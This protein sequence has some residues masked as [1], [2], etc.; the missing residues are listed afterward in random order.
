MQDGQEILP[1]FISTLSTFPYLLK[2]R[3]RSDG[4]ASYSKF[5]QKMG[6]IF[7]VTLKVITII[8]LYILDSVRSKLRQAT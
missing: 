7:P 2:S 1:D 6:L 4:R 5:P 8:I 3:S